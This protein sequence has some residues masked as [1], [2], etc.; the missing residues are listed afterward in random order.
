M[1]HREDGP[2]VISENNLKIYFDNGI[3]YNKINDEPTMKWNNTEVWTDKKGD[4]HRING[5]AIISGNRKEWYLNGKNHNMN[6]PAYV[7]GD[8]KEW[9][10][11][12]TDFDFEEWAEEK[13]RLE[14]LAIKYARVWYQ[15]CDKPG[16]KIWNNNMK[17][18]I[19][20]IDELMRKK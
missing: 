5:P 19:D 4:Y 1:P 12:G 13:L 10:I 9:Y 6:G 11:F 2:V 20:G 15:K 14:K 17:K 8:V 18:T 3:L 7:N 16:T